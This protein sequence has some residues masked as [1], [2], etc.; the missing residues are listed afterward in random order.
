[1]LRFAVSKSRQFLD[2]TDFR[3]AARDLR[4]GGAAKSL[5]T[6]FPNLKDYPMSIPIPLNTVLEKKPSQ[7]LFDS[8][9]NVLRDAIAHLPN[10]AAAVVALLLTWLA[11]FLFQK[12]IPKILNRTNWRSSLKE[13]LVTL[14]K[15]LVWLIGVMVAA[16]ILFPGLTPSKALGAAGLAS[17]AIG[18][19]F[20]DIF[21]NFFAGILLLWKFP[22]EPGDFIE[23]G[24]I[25]GKVIETELRLTTIRST[26]GELI[27][28][29]NAHLVGNPIEVLTDQELRRVGLKTG[30]AYGENVAEAIEVLEKAL[31]ECSTVSH[32]K[33]RDVLASGFGASSIDIDVLYWTESAPLDRRKSQSEVI[34]ALKKALD[35]AGIE[36]PFPYRTMTF[37]EPLKIEQS[38]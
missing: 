2:F 31:D 9:G 23:C 22:F 33:P 4:T 12:F 30:V 28:V 37:A 13:L 35:D 34:I 38:S 17:V 29:P 8:L 3:W 20:K 16:M 24:D 1:V 36:I 18:L 6:K 14:G 26:T 19:A 32:S 11:S 5:E 10:I 15:V 27:V 25:K 7:I 21:Q